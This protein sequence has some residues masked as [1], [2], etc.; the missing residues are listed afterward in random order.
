M[1]G[2][3][4]ESVDR[5]TVKQIS[6]TDVVVDPDLEDQTLSEMKTEGDSHSEQPE[7]IQARSISGGDPL[8]CCCPPCIRGFVLVLLIVA[9][10]AIG[11]S[12]AA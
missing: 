8:A 6:D 9:A 5:F 1:Y 2:T 4:V 7:L 10:G 3:K 12:L 11:R